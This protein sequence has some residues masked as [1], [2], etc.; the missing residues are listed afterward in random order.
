MFNHSSYIIIE[1]Y[2]LDLATDTMIG[3]NRVFQYYKIQPAR[4]LCFDKWTH[5]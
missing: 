5:S 3:N 2:L 4:N 1:M